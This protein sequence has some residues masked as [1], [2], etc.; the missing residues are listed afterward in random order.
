MNIKREDLPNLDQEPPISF[1]VIT[2]KEEV[3]AKAHLSAETVELL[4]V[5]VPTIRGKENPFLFPTNGKRHLDGD[6]VGWNLKELARK[7]GLRIP[8]GKRLSFHMF[9]KLFIST[10]KNLN[11]DPDTVKALCGKKVSASILTYMTTV[12]WREAFSKISEALKIQALPTRNH[13]KLEELVEQN[14]KL[15][16]QVAL[17]LQVVELQQK[18]L[19]EIDPKE[20]G[21]L[22][23][24]RDIIRRARKWKFPTENET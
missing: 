7:A 21:K 14:K 4:K 18:R 23:E 11:I 9:R 10:G 24:I 6:S 15:S 22:A 8:K 17:L 19:E 13:V 20:K 5:Y 2:G 3:L 1:D 16:S 12:Q